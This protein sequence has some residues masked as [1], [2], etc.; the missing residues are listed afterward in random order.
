MLTGRV[1]VLDMASG[2]EIDGQLISDVAV[3]LLTAQRRAA[4]S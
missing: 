3:L 2:N 1:C 4:W